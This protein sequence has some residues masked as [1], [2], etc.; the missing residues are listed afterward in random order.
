MAIL[1]GMKRLIINEEDPGEF[2]LLLIADSKTDNEDNMDLDEFAAS[3]G[4]D[5]H[6]FKD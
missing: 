4:F 6:E 3:L 5:V 2:D 1:T